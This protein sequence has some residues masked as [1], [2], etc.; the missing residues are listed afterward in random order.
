MPNRNYVKGR[1]AEYKTKKILERQ[2]LKVFRM[3]GSKSLWD[4]IG[5]LPATKQAP[6]KVFFFQVKYNCRPSKAEMKAMR[7]FPA[8][9]KRLWVW[10]KGKK[11]P[12]ANSQTIE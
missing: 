10:E 11:E 12:S 1:N 6:E 9:Y 4:L 3:A 7:Q 2:G 5:F 8:L